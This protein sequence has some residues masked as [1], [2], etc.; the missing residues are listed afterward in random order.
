[1]NCPYSLDALRRL[2]EQRGPGQPVENPLEQ[3]NEP[4]VAAADNRGD[5]DEPDDFDA[6]YESWVDFQTELALG[7]M[8]PEEAG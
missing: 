1:M 5:T 6:L 4:A 8:P 3:D 7:G 2:R